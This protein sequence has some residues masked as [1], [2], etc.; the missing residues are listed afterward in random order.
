MVTTVFPENR[1]FIIEKL[2]SD[3]SEQL[4]LKKLIFVVDQ[5]GN[6][7]FKDR[8][9]TVDD[10]SRLVAEQVKTAPDTAV[11]LQVDRRTRTENLIRVMDACKKGGAARVGIATKTHDQKS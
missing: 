8:H 2:E 7:Q 10:I 6:T 5:E 9:V 3:H 1:G 11:F 4:Q